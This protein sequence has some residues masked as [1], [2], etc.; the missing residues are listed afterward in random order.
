MMRK[1]SPR[2]VSIAV[3]QTK[4]KLEMWDQ[5]HRQIVRVVVGTRSAIFLPLTTN[6]GQFGSREKK[7]R[8]SKKH[9]NH[10]TMHGRWPG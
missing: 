1:E 6:S 8:R 7:M 2:S 5:I 3:F 4:R 9:K 10:A